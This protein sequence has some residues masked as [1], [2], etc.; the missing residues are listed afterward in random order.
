M[1][2]LPRHI[3]LACACACAAL[4]WLQNACNTEAQERGYPTYARIH[5]A[6][7]RVPLTSDD[8]GR[9]FVPVTYKGRTSDWLVD[10]GFFFS[11]LNQP[12]DIQ[13]ADTDHSHPIVVGTVAPRVHLDPILLSGGRVE[14]TGW[15]FLGGP[16]SG[17]PTF[18]ILGIGPLRAAYARLDFKART[19][20]FGGVP[21]PDRGSYIKI[22]LEKRDGG[23]LI[24][25]C[26]VG[27]SPIR[28]M[29]DSGSVI[30]LFDATSSSE[31]ASNGGPQRTVTTYDGTYSVT[32]VKT[33]AL[34]VGDFACR[35]PVATSKS[36][37]APESVFAQMGIFGILGADFLSK[38]GAIIALDENAMYISTTP[39]S[40]Q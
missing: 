9:L 38:T 10:T 1:R 23:I 24:A 20:T 18:N 33:A 32:M 12:A 35:M 40:T 39:R 26:Q 19:V 28:C 15:A 4:C 5:E 3:C 16:G 2:I 21:L 36:V 30:T 8:D 27:G 31:L 17:G 22:P 7:V 11:A 34:K 37:F 14:I 25:N 29:V 6:P 13:A